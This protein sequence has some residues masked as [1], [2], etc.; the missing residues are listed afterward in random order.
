M[1]PLVIGKARQHRSFNKTNPDS[2]PVIY[3]SNK[4]AWVTSKIYEEYLQI[5]Y[6][7]M[8]RQKRPFYYLLIMHHA[9]KTHIYRTFK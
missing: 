6:R 4:K 1:K 7:K 8:K 9:T 2:F 3:R 5:L